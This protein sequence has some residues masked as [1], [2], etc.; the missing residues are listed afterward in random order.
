MQNPRTQVLRLLNEALSTATA[1]EIQRAA[2][3]LEQAREVRM[4]K[5][6]LRRRSRI[7]QYRQDR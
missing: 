5:T 2:K 1:G 6:D 7:P 4:G 3:F